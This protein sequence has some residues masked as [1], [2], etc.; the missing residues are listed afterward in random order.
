MKKTINSNKHLKANQASSYF[1]YGR[2]MLAYFLTINNIHE[3][4]FLE[5]DFLKGLHFFSVHSAKMT[6]QNAKRRK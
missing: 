5:S 4:K 6:K 3:K 2:G 1:L